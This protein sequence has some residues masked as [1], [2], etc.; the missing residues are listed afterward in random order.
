MPE[1]CVVRLD[2]G[3]E[4]PT[5]ARAGDAGLDL[6]SAETLTI[7][8]GGE[9]ALVSTGVAVAIPDGWAG[10][11]LPRSGLASTRGVS[12][13]NAPGL[14]DSGYRGELRV[15]LINTDP[16]HIYELR[17]GDRIA[18]LLLIPAEAIQWQEVTSLP[19]SD[20]GEGGFGHTGR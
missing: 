15:L 1:V 5:Y 10:L 11:I 13:L 20:R 17:K 4:L 14:I 3:T 16:T 18:Q 8:P 2:P 6:S 12:V 19:A 7:G 9:R